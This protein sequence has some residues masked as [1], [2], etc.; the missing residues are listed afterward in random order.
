MPPQIMLSARVVVLKAFIVRAFA[1]IFLRP[2]GGI[3]PQIRVGLMNPDRVTL[4]SF[5]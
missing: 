4:G 5:C 1:G 3:L 2:D